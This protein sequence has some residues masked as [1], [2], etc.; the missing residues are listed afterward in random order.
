MGVLGGGLS[1]QLQPHRTEVSWPTGFA[2]TRSSTSL[3]AMYPSLLWL[4][5]PSLFSRRPAA[6]VAPA[7][8]PKAT[9]LPGIM[10]GDSDDDDEEEEEVISQVRRC[11]AC[12]GCPGGAGGGRR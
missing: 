1:A 2:T 12:G 11:L 3:A 6:P 10:G 8:P 4:V 5:W 9:S 7:P